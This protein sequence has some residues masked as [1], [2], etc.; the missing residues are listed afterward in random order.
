MISRERLP[1]PALDWGLNDSLAGIIHTLLNIISGL[2]APIGALIQ[3]IIGL[4]TG[5]GTA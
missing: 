2:V 4:F 5:G 1:K 3:Q